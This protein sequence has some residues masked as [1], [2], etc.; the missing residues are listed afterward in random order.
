[1]RECLEEALARPTF[2]VKKPI[3][4]IIDA[5]KNAKAK[6][7]PA[8]A[9]WITKHNLKTTA[10]SIVVL[11]NLGIQSITQLDALLTQSADE[12]Q[13]LQDEIGELETQMNALSQDMENVH[14]VHAYRE[15]YKYN[16]AHPEDKVFAEEYRSELAV[17]KVAA[18][19]ILD[20]YSGLP[21]GKDILNQLDDLAQKKNAL[22]SRY[23][24]N[25]A[26]FDVLMQYRWNY[27]QGIEK[28]WS[29]ERIVMDFSFN[30]SKSISSDSLRT[31]SSC[32]F[33]RC[34]SASLTFLIR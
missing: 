15:L 20:H 34:F 31:C 5:S 11:R 28:R 24:N 32:S 23:E 9:N 14:T 10:E 18:T 6:N 4:K 7:S 25:K 12:R 22:M 33:I 21:D 16:K 17:Y 27:E 26:Q 29:G 19:A 8:Y 2:A 3:G 1:M 30:Q 13:S